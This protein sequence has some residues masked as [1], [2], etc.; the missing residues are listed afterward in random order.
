MKIVTYDPI[1]TSWKSGPI[2]NEKKFD[3]DPYWII[4]PKFIYKRKWT[5]FT[6]YTGNTI[7][8]V[9][10]TNVAKI[11]IDTSPDLDS[12][13]IKAAGMAIKNKGCYGNGRGGSGK[14]HTIKLLVK[15]L[16]EQKIK[17]YGMAFT[18]IAV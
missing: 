10:Q 1:I 2:S 16:T 12:F 14:S 7:T 6:E 5:I 18:H 3:I 8:D 4:N 17:V 11:I 9:N 13:Q 15:E